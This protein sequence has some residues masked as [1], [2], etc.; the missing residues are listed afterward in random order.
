MKPSKYNICLPYDDRFVIFNGVTKRFFL[1]SSQNKD[2]FLKILSAPDEYKEK[3]V[4]FLK[5]MTDEGFVLEENADE[6]SNIRQQYESMNNSDVYHLMILPTY[7]CNVSCWYC[8]Q[9]HRNVFLSDS[10]IE[11]V[12][13]HIAY[14]LTNYP[15]KGL[16]LSWFGGEPLIRFDRVVEIAEYAQKYCIEN[17]LS[18]KN[19]ITTNGILLSHDILEKMKELEFTFFQITV[20]G[21]QE[22]HDKVKVIKGKSA[23]ET[24][25]RN[26][27]LITEIIP[28]AEICLRYN[29]TMK[30]IMPDE[31][32][33]NLNRYLS[34]DIRK[35]IRL[36]IMKIW[37]EDEN[38]V[39]E[40]QIDR[41]IENAYVSGYTV[42]AGP[43]FKTCYVEAHHFNCIFPNGEVDK[44]DNENFDNCRGKISADGNI[45]WSELPAFLEYNVYSHANECSDCQYLPVCYGPCPVEREKSAK[46]NKSLECRFT[47]KDKIWE[48]RIINYCKHFVYKSQ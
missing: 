11:K 43:G 46:N 1:V 9:H 37:Q 2:V 20:D 33:Q 23:Y 47:N 25:L 21:I 42:S 12:K 35:H 32:I 41:L 44:C 22:Q 16:H 31:F 4:P 48:Y 19:T 17:K 40:S 5:R 18:Y 10:D 8:T 38:G 7:A 3:Y 24:T 30:N 34:E 14:Y 36:S 26:V 13:K 29:F 27:C 28:S 15:V 45:V 6:L 39:D